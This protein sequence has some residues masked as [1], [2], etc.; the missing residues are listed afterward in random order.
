CVSE[1]SWLI[2]FATW[3]EKNLLNDYCLHPKGNPLNLRFN[4]KILVKCYN[5]IILREWYSLYMNDTQVF[6][7][8]T[9]NNTHGF[10]MLIKDKF[11][12]SRRNDA[13]GVS[14][15][16]IVL[17]TGVIS[18][19][20]TKPGGYYRTL[21][22]ISKIINLKLNVTILNRAVVGNWNEYGGLVKKLINNETDIIVG[23]IIMTVGRLNSID[24][25]TPTSTSLVLFIQ[26]INVKQK[27]L[28]YF[29]TFHY[30][31][32]IVIFV[33]IL[34]VPVILTIM[35]IYINRNEIYNWKNQYPDNL[36]NVWR[37]FCLQ[38]T[39][40]FPKETPLRLTWFTIFTSAL[41][42]SFVYSGYLIN[43]IARPSYVPSF[44]SLENFIN[45]A[46]G[47][48]NEFG[49]LV[50][51]LMNNE[52]DIAV[53]NMI[54]TVGRLKLVDFAT[55]ISTSRL[56]LCIQ[57]TNVKR[58]YLK[59]FKTFH[60]DI[61]IVIIFFILTVPVILT[62]MNIYINR[63]E[64]YN[65]KN[66]YPDNLFNVWRMF[67]LQGTAEFPN[68]TPL[69]LTWFTIFVSALIISLI[70]SGS[71]INYLSIKSPVP[72]FTSLESFI[73]DG[74]YKL[75]VLKNKY[76]YHLIQN[77]SKNNTVLLKLRQFLKHQNELPENDFQ[78][79][80]EVICKK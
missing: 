23:N 47:N 10:K 28:N 55:P 36:F 68:E 13:G 49:G 21:L 67:C 64:I 53:A 4:T 8:A 33:F 77:A 76:I 59:Y 48:W 56:V 45:D 80:K 29:K 63:N 24:F 61:W 46:A 62:I 37:M 19:N 15:R 12:Y 75:V 65:W 42:I 60:Y 17:N 14:L 79:I 18:Q 20:F 70:Y 39:S 16:V 73:N 43:Y 9:W 44:M 66:Q 3:Q 6:H 34:T 26:D 25:V 54:M 30:D 57:E 27:Y 52:T 51:K 50:A 7:L 69:R 22:T 5:D 2:I 1:N 78:A 71:L 40:E 72:T 58:K 74:T 35:N 32:W 31:I 11:L 41:I 38:G